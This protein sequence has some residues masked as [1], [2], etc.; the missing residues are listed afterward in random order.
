MTASRHAIGGEIEVWTRGDLTMLPDGDGN[1]GLA[2]ATRSS[3][4]WSSGIRGGHGLLVVRKGC[5]VQS[6]DLVGLRG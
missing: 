3:V 5:G 1:P 4:T 2:W 6:S